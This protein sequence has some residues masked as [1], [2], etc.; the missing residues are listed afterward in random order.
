MIQIKKQV[1]NDVGNGFNC[2]NL[3]MLNK[4]IYNIGIHTVILV[5]NKNTMNHVTY[6]D[7]RV[8]MFK[9]LIFNS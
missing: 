2:K 1:K 9:S 7:I 8:L 3:K 4:I 6:I 5:Y